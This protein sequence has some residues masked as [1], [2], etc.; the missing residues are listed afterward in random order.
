MDSPNSAAAFCGDVDSVG[1]D[2][3]VDSPNVSS[4]SSQTPRSDWVPESASIFAKA[5]AISESS[6]VGVGFGVLASL[7]SSL[8]SES[9]F[10]FG[11]D[12]EDNA[13]A[14]VA[15]P[16][17]G[18]AAFAKPGTTESEATELDVTD[19]VLAAAKIEESGLLGWIVVTGIDFLVFSAASGFE[20]SLLNGL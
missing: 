14:R 2:S 8:V 20:V 4:A 10:S 11:A 6:I 9:A 3:N 13:A 18:T 5:A 19:P 17:T 7:P 1:P 16:A 15:A 12:D